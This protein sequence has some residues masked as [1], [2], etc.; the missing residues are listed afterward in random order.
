[1]AC[2]R[3]AA[4][5]S[6]RSY[7]V[8]IKDYSGNTPCTVGVGECDQLFIL[9]FPGPVIGTCMWERDQHR[10]QLDL[11]EVYQGLHPVGVVTPAR[12]P[13]KTYPSGVSTQPAARV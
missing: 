9:W 6:A 8:S 5:H 12:C 13:F 1:M 11:H 4:T 3:S 10:T 2:D 7:G